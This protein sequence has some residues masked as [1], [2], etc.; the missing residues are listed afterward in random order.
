[1]RYAATLKVI[2]AP[3]RVYSINLFWPSNGQMKIQVDYFDQS[4]LAIISSREKCKHGGLGH[5]LSKIRLKIT[6]S[7]TLP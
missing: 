5:P 7:G 2:T 6:D 3:D 1:M 4:V